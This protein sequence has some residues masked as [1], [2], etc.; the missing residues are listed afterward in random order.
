VKIFERIQVH[1]RQFGSTLLVAERSQKSEAASVLPPGSALK[2][3]AI[4]SVLADFTMAL[5]ESLDGCGYRPLWRSNSDRGGRRISWTPN[6]VLI[7]LGFKAFHDRGESPICNLTAPRS[8]GLPDPLPVVQAIDMKWAIA[9]VQPYLSAT[10][11]EV[12]AGSEV[13]PVRVKL[14]ISVHVCDITSR[15][16]ASRARIFCSVI[17]VDAGCGSG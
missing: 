3:A 13:S 1:A 14:A 5:E 4:F 8:E 17:R 2:I 10:R 15:P 12:R 11:P 16:R 7:S 6:I 9:L